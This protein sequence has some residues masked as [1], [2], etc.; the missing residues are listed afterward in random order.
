MDKSDA[1]ALA[2]MRHRHAKFLAEAVAKEMAQSGNP[3][4]DHLRSTLVSVFERENVVVLS[5]YSHRDNGAREGVGGVEP[6]ATRSD[7]ERLF[8]ALKRYSFL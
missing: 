5:A 7:R 8:E 6:V 3:I 1:K 4:G 2:D